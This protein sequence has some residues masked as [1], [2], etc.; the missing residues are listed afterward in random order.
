[1]CAQKK[2]KQHSSKRDRESNISYVDWVIICIDRGTWNEWSHILQNDIGK[3]EA[4]NRCCKI[5][6]LSI[7]IYPMVK[8][9]PN[10]W[11]TNCDSQH[12]HC[13]MRNAHTDVCKSKTQPTETLDNFW[14]KYDSLFYRL[15]Y[16][17]W[18]CELVGSHICV[19]S[20]GIDVLD[21]DFLWK[22]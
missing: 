10:L 20:D 19:V 11:I 18:L 9:D 17:N 22:M 8:Y 4:F 21:K 13:T 15:Q 1:M 7:T 3:E 2:R 14:I 6:I 12:G 16:C 5:Y